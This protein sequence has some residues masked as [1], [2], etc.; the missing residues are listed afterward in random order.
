M[1]REFGLMALLMFLEACRGG[2]RTDD[3]APTSSTQQPS[4]VGDQ[5]ASAQGAYIADMGSGP[6]SMPLVGNELALGGGIA[7][8]CTGQVART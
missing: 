8:K 4:T 2:P 1:Q 6:R 5:E 7:Q 3:E